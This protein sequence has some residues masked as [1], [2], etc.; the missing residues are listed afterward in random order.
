MSMG[1][2]VELHLY[3]SEDPPTHL[4]LGAVHRKDDAP[5]RRSF[6]APPREVTEA[7]ALNQIAEAQAMTGGALG[8]QQKMPDR[9][10]EL[11]DYAEEIVSKMCPN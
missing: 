8:P 10:K 1:D 6:D 7:D 4:I 11:A 3:W 5:R 2:A 9:L